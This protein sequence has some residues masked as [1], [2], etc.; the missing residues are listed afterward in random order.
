MSSLN[1]HP[2]SS[3]LLLEVATSLYLVTHRVPSQNLLNTRPKHQ[4]LHALVV[5]S[6]HLLP[7]PYPL[8][9]IPNQSE[10]IQC[11]ASSSIWVTRQPMATKTQFQK[12]DGKEI[13]KA[14]FCRKEYEQATRA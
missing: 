11:S 13:Y 7:F 2:H 4:L 5:L 1:L 10:E 6:S 9:A 8:S 14:K 3:N 12:Q